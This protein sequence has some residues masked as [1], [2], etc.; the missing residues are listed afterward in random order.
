[1]FEEDRGPAQENLAR[2]RAGEISS[3]RLERR[4]IRKDGDTRWADVVVSA[5]LDVEHNYLGSVTIVNDIT[6][7]KQMEDE[8]REARG[9]AEEAT[10]TK[11]MFLA[12][13]SHEIRTPMNAIIGMSHLALKTEL[14]PRQRDYVQKIHGAGTALLGIINDILDFSKIEA[15]KLTLEKT[16]FDLEEVMSGVSTVIGQKVFDKG[17]ELL[18]DV[19]AE[20][21]RRLVGDPLRIGQ[22]LTNLVNNSVKF[23]ENGEVHVKVSVAER[24]GDRTKLEF[25]VRD[26]GIGMTPEQ[27]ARM[28]QPFSQAD[29]STTRKYGGTGLGLTIC[30]RLGWARQGEAPSRS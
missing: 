18:F 4:Y 25:A 20:V 28:F 1:M 17:L 10:K 11:S 12:N 2:L 24:Y 21:P 16:D 22:I 8:L 7:R 26:T 29:G 23:T 9:V 3:F 5:I 19:T 27:S 30:K 6:E 15:D 13:M 14:N